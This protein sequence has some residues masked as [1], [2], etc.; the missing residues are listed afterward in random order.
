MTST[1]YFNTFFNDI[2]R[3]WVATTSSSD[4]SVLAA[5]EYGGYIYTSTDYGVNWTARMNDL[6][7]NWSCIACS[8]NGSKM[9]AAVYGEN[10]YRSTN[11]GKTWVTSVSIVDRTS[12]V[13]N[14]NSVASSS[15]DDT[16]FVACTT[17][18]T[19]PTS[20][21]NLQLWLD[22]NDYSTLIFSGSSVIKWNDKSGYRYDATPYNSTSGSSNFSTYSPTGLNNL[23]AIQLNKTG[24]SARSPPGTFI[25]GITFFVV[26]K[27][28][29]S[30]VNVNEALINKTIYNSPSP[31][32]I[33]NDTKLVSNGT[34]FF[35]I[36]VGSVSSST[37]PGSVAVNIKN[38]TLATLYSSTINNSQWNEYVN[39]SLKYT[40]NYVTVN[41]TDVSSNIYIGTR[42]SKNTAF[43]GL[44]SE[45]IVYNRV[46]IN[47]ERQLV[48]RYLATKW[49]ISDPSLLTNSIND[50][51]IYTSI[52]SGANW[53]R[54]RQNDMSRN[55]SS[56]ASSSDGTYLLASVNNG[57]LYTK[58]SNTWET[59]RMNDLYRNWS[60]VSSSNDGKMM[61]ACV[62]Y[63]YLYTSIDYGV[64]WSPRMVDLSRNWSSVTSSA[65]GINLFA[66]AQNGQLYASNDYGIN[67][68][69]ND[70]SRNWSS[71]TLSRMTLIA[72][73]NN[74]YL[75]ILKFITYYKKKKK[76][77]T[78]YYIRREDLLSIQPNSQSLTLNTGGFKMSN[79]LID[80]AFSFYKYGLRYNSFFKVNNVDLGSL[81]QTT[82]VLY[83]Y[84]NITTP[85]WNKTPTTFTNAKFIWSNSLLPTQ[86]NYTQIYKYFFYYSF[87]YTQPDI[88]GY[89]YA[90]CNNA[91]TE[92]GF[93][94]G[95]SGKLI[96]NVNNSVWS[97][98]TPSYPT[99]S[100]ITIKKGLNCIKIG[101]YNN[102]IPSGLYAD[103]DAT[104]NNNFTFDTTIPGNVSIWSSANDSSKIL[105]QTISTNRPSLI[106]NFINS[107]PVVYFGTNGYILN[108][109]LLKKDVKIIGNITLFF[110][111][112]INGLG[113]LR[114]TFCS[115]N[116]I[117]TI[118]SLHLSIDYSTVS[119]IS[120]LVISFNTVNG[121][122]DWVTP[123]VIKLFHTYIL[124]I[125]IS[126]N[127]AK[128]RY[129]GIP[130]DIS[131]SY[132]GSNTAIL[133]NLDIGG[134][135]NDPGVT[136]VGGIGEFIQYNKT[137]SL[138][139][140][141]QV[142]Y[143][144]GLKW[145]L[146]SFGPSVQSSS[147]GLYCYYYSN[148]YFD[149][150]FELFGTRP[151]TL[152]NKNITNFSNE[153]Y[154]ITNTTTYVVQNYSTYMWYG[155]FKSPYSSPTDISFGLN[156]DDASYLWFGDNAMDGNYTKA[157]ANIDNSGIHGLT[158][159]QCR[160]NV[161]NDIYYPIR[162]IYGQRDAGHG[163]QFYYI[164][165]ETNIKV[166]D[167]S[168]VVFY[169]TYSTGLYCYL[170]N[171]YYFDLSYDI[172]QTRPYTLYNRNITNF[173]NH[174]YAI[175]NTNI[176]YYTVQNYS[177][178]MWYGLFKSPY[179]SPTDISFGLNTDDGSYL[180]FGDNAMDGNYTKANASINNGHLGV[181]E[182]QCRINVKNDIYYPIRIIYGQRVGLPVFQFYYMITTTK[183][184]DLSNVVFYPSN[185]DGLIVSV[186]DINN[187]SI[188]YTNENWTYSVVD[189]S[190]SDTVTNVT[191]TFGFGDPYY[192]YEE[193]TDPP[194]DD[195]PPDDP[196]PDVIV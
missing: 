52:D 89:I 63:G 191:N 48:E 45:V 96:S 75:Y 146:S 131:Y 65:D 40:N 54:Q 184:Y 35:N 23:P 9:V 78:S 190:F 177:T 120:N 91:A 42:S 193:A 135:S 36:T 79:V 123:L 194:P 51:Y 11:S 114:Q 188:A 196:P 115:T 59:P 71:V 26:F 166:Y 178:Y 183:V 157:N 167:L 17:I 34:G 86:L 97:T 148:Y 192:F 126:D 73:V 110:V 69:A 72:S 195:P 132:S 175:L 165:P 163:F 28:T 19:M 16:K 151:Y 108:T 94:G 174:S 57:Y 121:M 21:P 6:T 61:V 182:K 99:P 7:R 144:L 124:T 92:I 95:A 93:N 30:T 102:R 33:Y 29:T 107:L 43:D 113:G 109:N 67:W 3:N 155:L 159:K 12:I 44:I 70:L 49:N 56:V 176:E 128:Y 18:S 106:A 129:N 15:V 8:G 98:I 81:F 46:L 53:T 41:F 80:K 140:M 85:K 180:W 90:T 125:N 169:P 20:I 185:P 160:I 47:N 158:D 117:K 187:N 118:G 66:T 74:E 10:I 141:Q 150:S 5:C 77:L 62:N 39:G 133:Y 181:Q 138:I 55:W 189:L 1:P 156:S 149:T 111:I 50:G 24:F 122:T 145:G 27:K 22:A 58:I 112:K 119:Q 4:G 83:V 76:D 31:F 179:S 37:T 64:N 153:S 137:L 104:L 152:I 170:Y 101:V 105:Q 168:N 171:N 100:S 162:I 68:I 142:E 139:E 134:W 147:I 14:W 13:S 32:D 88:S 164:I 2:S 60:S 87:Y 127:V 172:F 154:A 82:D 173:S 186:Y 116:G 143:Y 25:N 103:F 84:T 130:E 38:Q 136:F 161:V